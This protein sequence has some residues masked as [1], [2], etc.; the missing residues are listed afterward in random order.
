MTPSS[1]YVT[2]SATLREIA[3]APG[4]FRRPSTFPLGARTSSNA[5]GSRWT[6]CA[7]SVA[8]A[9]VISS[10]LTGCVPSVIEHTGCSFVV[11]PILCATGTTFQGPTFATSWAKIVFTEFAVALR[12]FM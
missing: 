8:Y 2:W 11:M 6:P 10:G 1:A 9:S 3:C 5:C 4:A 7:A 12:R